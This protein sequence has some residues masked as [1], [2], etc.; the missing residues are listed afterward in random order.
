MLHLETGIKESKRALSLGAALPTAVWVWLHFYKLSQLRWWVSSDHL[1][2]SAQ[3][4]CQ[5]PWWH[6]QEVTRVLSS[7]SSKQLLHA[8]L[9][10]WA[11]FGCSHVSFSLA[12]SYASVV[13]PDPRAIISWAICLGVAVWL[14]EGSC[15]AAY[16][17]SHPVFPAPVLCCPSF[18]DRGL[19]HPW[20]VHSSLC[21]LWR[22]LWSISS[23]CLRMLVGACVFISV[24]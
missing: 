6:F 2:S 14:G 15:A 16:A 1:P 22:N 3:F 21:C 12:T 20:S 9:F 23:V 11:L 10:V 8:E 18:D 4:W 19:L 7:N 13:N 24:M 17:L 5:F